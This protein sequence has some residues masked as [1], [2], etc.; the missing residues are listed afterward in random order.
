MNIVIIVS[1]ILSCISIVAIGKLVLED[2]NSRKRA[3]QRYEQDPTV[4]PLVEEFY[5]PNVS[6]GNIINWTVFWVLPGVNLFT[7]GVSVCYAGYLQLK[8]VWNEPLINW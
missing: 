1:L 8:K 3:R 6:I 7:L 4:E 2:Y 5:V